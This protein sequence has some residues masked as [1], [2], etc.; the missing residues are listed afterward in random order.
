MPHPLDEALKREAGGKLRTLPVR[1]LFKNPALN[2]CADYSLFDRDSGRPV[3]VGKGE[4]CRRVGNEGVESPPCPGLDTCRFAYGQCNTYVR[5]NVVI[6]DS[7]D[8]TLGSF[9][10]RTTSFNTIHTLAA[11]LQYFSAVSGGLL[12]CLPLELKLRGKSTTMSHRSAAYYVAFLMRSSLN[13][14]Q[15]IDEA[16]QMDECRR[17]IGFDQ[18]ALDEV[19]RQG[20]ANGAFEKM[21]EDVPMVVEEFY[22]K[23]ARDEVI[24]PKS[25]RSQK[26]NFLVV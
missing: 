13:L 11:R 15:A 14:E 2:L 7:Q 25:S 22:S 1:L 21:G 17:A 5:F 16:R 23:E 6:G 10:L 20:F 12:A 9:A 4:S 26:W 18:E 24:P 8:D 3:C 19:T